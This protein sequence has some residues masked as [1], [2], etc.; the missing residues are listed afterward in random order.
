MVKLAKVFEGISTRYDEFTNRNMGGMYRRKTVK[1]R[2][3]V[4]MVSCLTRLKT[5]RIVKY[6]YLAMTLNHIKI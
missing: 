2:K 4:G 3:W 6:W 1:Y 5:S